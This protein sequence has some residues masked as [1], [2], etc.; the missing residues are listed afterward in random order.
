M[1]TTS[2]W[3]RRA[4]ARRAAVWTLKD[5]TRV[6]RRRGWRARETWM[7]IMFPIRYV[8]RAMRDLAQR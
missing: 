6:E 8:A 4:A 3:M 2:S 1:S 5:R 7:K